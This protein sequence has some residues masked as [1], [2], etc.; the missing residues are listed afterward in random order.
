MRKKFVVLGVVTALIGSSVVI[1]AMVPAA[2]QQQ[3]TTFTVCDRNRGGYNKDVD[4]GKKGFSP[5]DQFLEIDTLRRPKSG[6]KVGK[7]VVRGSFVRI[8]RKRDDAL[9]IVDFTATFRNGKISGYGYTRFSNFQAQGGKF[10][11]VGGTESYNDVRGAVVVK[12]GQCG[13]KPGTR[14]TFNL[15]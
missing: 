2:S 9:F 6:A 4:L 3:G 10:A 12:S 14:I 5:G 8:F 11:V 7:L 15:A 13:G 1:G